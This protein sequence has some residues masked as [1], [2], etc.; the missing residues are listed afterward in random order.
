V[1]E[2][3]SEQGAKRERPSAGGCYASAY[4]SA[5]A[6]RPRYNG[7]A[8]QELTIADLEGIVK[9]LN[10]LQKQV[11]AK[12]EELA[13]LREVR[14]EKAAAFKQ[15]KALESDLAL[16]KKEVDK[17]NMAVKADTEDLNEQADR[18][19]K[20][21]RQQLA[22][23]LVYHSAMK[24]QLQTDG[25]EVVAFVANVSPEILKALDVESG[26]VKYADTFLG[27]LPSKVLQNGFKLSL[28]RNLTL[29]YVKTTCE[30]RVDGRYKM[31]ARGK[32]ANPQK[33]SKKATGKKSGNPS[34]Q[35]IEQDEDTCEDDMPEDDKESEHGLAT[36]EQ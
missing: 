31:H 2:H 32:G 22:A 21:I 1:S 29:K 4:A 34:K 27:S 11:V 17:L 20:V 33:S 12:E 16:C 19:R 5:A 23:Q 9:E 35:V 10:S 18:V 30:L 36:E 15:I 3:G 13:V 8:F 24:D 28:A 14:S 25:R 26:K 6:K 7:R